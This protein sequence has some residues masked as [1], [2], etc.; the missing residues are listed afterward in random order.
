MMTTHR[1]HILEEACGPEPSEQ[2]IQSVMDRVR[3]EAELIPFHG[4]PYSS[5]RAGG[6]TAAVAAAAAALIALL[7]WASLPSNEELAWNAQT[8]G[9]VSEYLL[10]AER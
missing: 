4:A 8:G 7:G 1:V 5:P 2:W 6:G 3:A 10:L 9:Y